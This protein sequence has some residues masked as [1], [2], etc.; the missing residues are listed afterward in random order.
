MN[1]HSKACILGGTGFVGR[2]LARR[3]TARGYQ[4][5]LPTRRAHRHRDLRLV[6]GIQLHPLD[7]LDQP[8]LT[9][10]FAGCDLVVNLIG[11]LNESARSRFQQVHVELVE[12]VLAAA[13]EAE[14]PRLLHMSALHACS[15]GQESA[16]A[17]PPSEYLKSKG[18]GE[19]LALSAQAPVATAF[20]PS[21]IF[22]RRDSLLNRFAGL[23]D[24]TPGFFPLACSGARFAPVWVGDVAEAMVRALDRADSP[25]RAYDLCGP[26]V[27]SLRELVEYT[28]K[29]RGRKIK[30]IELSDKA[31]QRQA[32]LFERLPGKPFTMDN[33]RSLQ[34]DSVCTGES[35]LR[36]LGIEPTDIALEAPSYLAKA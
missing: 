8:S 27:F 20:R 25:G 1:T 36:E 2:E 18:A 23:I 3:L 21:V 34:M 31:A 16:A 22:G 11:I 29:L 33:Y 4:C 13:R 32:R 30:I 9:Q 26:R 10:A 19:A 15:P 12:R 24:W 7:S 35:G 28:A 17:H 5:H 6:P 14:V